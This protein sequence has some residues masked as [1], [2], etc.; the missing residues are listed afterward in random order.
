M[1][2]SE[3]GLKVSKH[4]VWL[5]RFARCFGR[6]DALKTHEV[7]AMENALAQMDG[8]EPVE[9]GTIHTPRLWSEDGWTANVV[10]NEDDD[11]WAVQMIKEG[12]REPALVGP[13]TMGRDKK[14][15]KPLDKGAF[16]TLVKT[17]KEFVGRTAQQRHARL[18]KEVE[19]GSAPERV[20]VHLDIV[21]DEDFPYAVLSAYDEGREQLGKQ[22]VGA[23]FKL[24]SEAAEKWINSGYSKAR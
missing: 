10:K 21:P 24:T 23:D 12:E 14:N 3:S 18:H 13:W 6:V 5:W 9:D 7:L 20:F 11:G 22:Q 1:S 15:P 17:A 19:I 8:D 4:G 2:G 16:L